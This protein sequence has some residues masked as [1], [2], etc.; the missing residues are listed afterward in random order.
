M[1]TS[2][3]RSQTA[4]ANAA[5]RRQKEVERQAERETIKRGLLSVMD[6]DTATNAERLRA[7]E[8]LKGYNL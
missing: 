5:K 7:A 2:E 8:I 4:K 1:T 6:S 3:K